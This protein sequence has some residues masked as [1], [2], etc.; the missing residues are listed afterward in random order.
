[1]IIV[2]EERSG[3]RIEIFLVRLKTT[4]LQPASRRVRVQEVRHGRREDRNFGKS[5]IRPRSEAMKVIVISIVIAALVAACA[6]L[7][8]S[9][10]QEPAYEA[11]TVPHVRVGN[12]GDNLVG[13]EWSGDWGQ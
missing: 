8:L 7:I 13:P 10:V 3:I 5:L 6:G 12:P 4:S 9:L 11:F 1:L 2:N